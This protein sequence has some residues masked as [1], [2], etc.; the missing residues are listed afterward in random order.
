MKTCPFCAEQIQ[1]D[2]IKCRYCNEFLDGSRPPLPT[3]KSKVPWYFST[4]TITL[5]FLC[6]GPLILP[7][8][9]FH[10]T[11]SNN[12]KIIITVIMAVIT[13]IAWK[14][15]SFG[16]HYIMQYYGTVLH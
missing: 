11:W 4:G 8:V 14:A 9:W 15:T 13:W 2:A 16:M 5:G 6:V 1:D 7:L 3:P 10:P 12:K